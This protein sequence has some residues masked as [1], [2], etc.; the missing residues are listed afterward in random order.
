MAKTPATKKRSKVRVTKANP[1]LSKV[2]KNNA[3]KQLRKE[4]YR[5][6]LNLGFSPVDARKYRDHSSGSIDSH[7]EV[8]RKR[9]AKVRSAKR[10]ETDTQKIK[11]IRAFNRQ[12]PAVEFQGRNKTKND[13]W[14]EFSDWT[15]NRN[16]PVWAM[17]Y[18][19]E[20]NAKQGVDPLDS[21]GFR[22]FYYRYVMN[23][24]E[25]TSAKLADRDDS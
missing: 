6:M 9:I 11:K 8:E 7:I 25:A 12:K 13:R 10:V 22:R 3:R 16:F 2:A 20:M 19:Q 17:E 5:H 4:R 24:T 14:E 1:S 18:I 21:W 23:R 15:R